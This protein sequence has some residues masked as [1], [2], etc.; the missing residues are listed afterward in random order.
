VDQRLLGSYN[1]REFKARMR[2]SRVTFTYI[3]STL[4]P[5]LQKCSMVM[6]DLI[7]AES[8]VAIATSRLATGDCM[9]SI[10]DKYRVGFSSSQKIVSEFISATK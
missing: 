9:Q 4:A 7:P 1:E 8:R 5:L 6:G 10:A 2:M 3:C